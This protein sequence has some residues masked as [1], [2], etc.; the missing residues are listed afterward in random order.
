MPLPEP[1][2]RAALVHAM[3]RMHASGL[4]RGT[5]GNASIR[6]DHGMVV[7]PSGIGPDAL[8][9]EMMVFVS[10][11]GEPAAA[12]LRPSTEYRMHHHI[13]RARPDAQAVMHC[14]SRH[15][16]ILACCNKPIEPIH[17]MVLVAGASRIAIAPF[18]PFGTEALAMHALAAMAGAHA[19]LLAHH[20]Q[21][22]LG[23]TWQQALSIAEE[24]EEQAAITYGALLLGGAPTLTATEL[25]ETMAQFR[26][27]GQ[28]AA[29]TPTRL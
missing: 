10:E 18:A 3:R 26:G 27:Y 14:H 5:S 4:N 1:E 11:T 29:H 17:Y 6:V 25:A 9:P 12:G 20:G 15:A 19:C 28:A 2:A 8:T 24:I 16:T 22:A 7:T 13:L 21:V 23:A